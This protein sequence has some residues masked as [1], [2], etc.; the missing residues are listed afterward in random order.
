[1]NAEEIKLCAMGGCDLSRWSHRLEWSEPVGPMCYFKIP[2]E[3]RKEKLMCPLPRPTWWRAFA[4]LASLVAIAPS[5]MPMQ[6]NFAD[7]LRTTLAGKSTRRDFKQRAAEPRE[8]GD[9]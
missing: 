9:E 8:P 6:T 5:P 4:P 1:M 7:A 2:G 3:C